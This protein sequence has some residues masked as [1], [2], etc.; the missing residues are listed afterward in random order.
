M[1]IQIC[2]RLT[3]KAANDFQMADS[4]TIL[5]SPKARVPEWIT[6]ETR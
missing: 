4:F 3:L 1:E 5:L 6:A 2:G